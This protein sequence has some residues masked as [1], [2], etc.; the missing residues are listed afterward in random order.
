MFLEDL[1]D[2]TGGDISY[3]PWLN[4]S[5]LLTELGKR[6]VRDQRHSDRN[7]GHRSN[8]TSFSNAYGDGSNF[9]FPPRGGTGPHRGR[10]GGRGG[11]RRN[12]GRRSNSRQGGATS[13]Q[14]AGQVEQGQQ[15][16][17]TAILQSLAALATQHKDNVCP[18]VVPAT[19]HTA[20][21]PKQ[22][23]TNSSPSISLSP[24]PTLLSSKSNVDLLSTSAARSKNIESRRST[25]KTAPLRQKPNPCY[26]FI[27]RTNSTCYRSSRSSPCPERESRREPISNSSRPR[28]L[29]RYANAPTPVHPKGAPPDRRAHSRHPLSRRTSVQNLRRW[30][31]QDRNRAAEMDS[32]IQRTLDELREWQRTQE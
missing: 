3:R 5:E 18:D 30:M 29:V 13:A 1:K 27:N 28:L 14:D 11:N 16:G 10:G 6:P 15:Q 12:Q 32:R 23:S 25:P 19:R 9:Q 20:P 24:S 17:W 4:T 22:R 26:Y 7:A 8:S 2:A 21:A 31:R